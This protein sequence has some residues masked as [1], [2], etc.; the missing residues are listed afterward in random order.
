MVKLCCGDFVQRYFS[1]NKINNN[2][3]LNNDDMYHI[4][5]VMRM[6]T[7]DKIEVIYNEILYI[8][9]IINLENNEV[10]IIEKLDINNEFSKYII[11]AF[12]LM[13]EDKI[14]LILQKCCEIG[15]S[16]FIPIITERC[17][18]KPSNM[19]NKFER[20]NKILKE[21][22]EQSKRNIIP[23][24]NE[25]INIKKL[26]NFKSDLK[27]LCSLEKNSKNL[28][29][30]LQNN[31]NCD[32]ILIV[33]GPEGGLSNLEEEILVNNNFLRTSIGSTVKRAET[34]PIYVS[35]SI[36]YEFEKE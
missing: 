6:R 31:Q 33:S 35:S 24:I 1:K 20:W 18:V 11:V 16:E 14:N 2:L 17:V 10:E 3:L 4:K 34:A 8:C 32:R 36:N 26:I 9:K 19:E 5:K 25:I 28:K 23:K 13:K 29:N 12:P 27:I 15:V 22:S 21:A 30:I 7:N